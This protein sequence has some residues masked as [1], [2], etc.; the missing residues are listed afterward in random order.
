MGNLSRRRETK[1]TVC[2]KQKV[3]VELFQ[4]LAGIEGAAPLIDLRR[5]RNTQDFRKSS[6]FCFFFSSLKEKKK[7]ETV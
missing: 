3:L 7:R 2:R 5:G 6:S 1:K 4:K